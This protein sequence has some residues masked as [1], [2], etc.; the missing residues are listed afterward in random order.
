PRNWPCLLRYD[1]NLF[2]EL[3][4]LLNDIY[5]VNRG[6]SRR[7]FKFGCQDSH[8]SSLSRT[9]PPYQYKNASRRQSKVQGIKSSRFGLAVN[10]GQMIAYNLPRVLHHYLPLANTADSNQSNN[11][12]R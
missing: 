2:P 1:S 5:S 4:C 10:F 7:R 6:A 9:V 3:A 12:T 8:K 11:N